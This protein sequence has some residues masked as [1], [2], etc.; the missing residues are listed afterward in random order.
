MMNPRK[1]ILAGFL[2]AGLAMFQAGCAKSET[3]SASVAQEE[4]A[5]ENGNGENAGEG[6]ASPQE[7]SAA[8]GGSQSSASSAR[9]ASSQPA[10]RPS[11]GSTASSAPSGSAASEMTGGSTA[12]G[13][14]DQPAGSVSTAAATPAVQTYTLPPGATVRVRTGAQISSSD[15]KD[16]DTFNATLAEP[17][18]VDGR[19]IADRGAR[20]TGRV[21]TSDPG[22]R[23]KGRAI[24]RVAVTSVELVNGE[25]AN[26]TVGH[27]EQEAA[28]AAG[29]DAA[30]VAVGS[31]VGAA[32]GA[33]AGGGRGAAIGAGVGAGAGTGAV[34]ATRGNAAVIPAES[35][36]NFTTQNQISVELPQ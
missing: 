32:I 27:F 23:I 35:V 20:V 21:V 1:L 11:G 6:E 17:L 4:E 26:L 22:G 2:V 30:K 25:R 24:L 34:L 16:G 12:S 7:G 15:Q 3:E 31:G 19:T 9:P 18:I 28:S 29:R 36:L 33:I 13:W 10:S 14:G 8:G 5:I